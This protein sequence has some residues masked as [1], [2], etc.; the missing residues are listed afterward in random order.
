MKSVLFRRRGLLLGAVAWTLVPMTAKSFPERQV[1]LIVPLPAGSISD[2]QGRQLAQKL[3]EIWQRP[4]LVENRPGA[5]NIVGHEA[6]ARAAPD[7]HTLLR[8]TIGPLALL[9]HLMKLPFDPLVDFIPVTRVTAGPLVLVA[10]PDAPFDSVDAMVRHSRAHPGH[11]KVAGFGVGTIGHLAVLLTAKVT[12]AD[13]GHVPYSGG[14]QQVADLVGGQVPLLFDFS[15]VLEPHVRAGKARALSVTGERRLPNLPEVPTFDELGYRGLRITA[16]QGIV[17]P[18]RTPASIV[19]RL[20]ADLAK[21]L[22]SPDLRDAFAAVG[23]D[24]GGEPPDVFAA[25]V[26][27]EHARWGRLIAEAKIRLE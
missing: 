24:V 7:G 14:P 9:P 4:L 3:G 15:P 11:V 21:A 23:A 1:R 17:V 2:V 19:A 18:A 10:H 27:A 22:A 13:L 12:G 16:W 6:G 25:F 26:R 5:G 8:A 20:H